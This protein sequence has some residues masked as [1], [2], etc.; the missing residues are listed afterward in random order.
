MTMPPTW[1]KNLSSP[2]IRRLILLST[3]V[4]VDPSKLLR[5]KQTL[6]P[7]IHLPSQ[8]QLKQRRL[9]RKPKRCFAYS[10]YR[11]LNCML[12]CLRPNLASSKNGQ[13]PLGMKGRVNWL[14]LLP[15]EI[16][17]NSNYMGSSWDLRLYCWQRRN[18]ETT[19]RAMRW[20][21][22]LLMLTDI[23]PLKCSWATRLRSQLN[24]NWI[25]S[26]FQRRPL[27]ASI[28]PL[29]GKTKT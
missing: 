18:R 16:R 4:W 13:R 29:L 25:T 26:S 27:S 14:R 20:T 8:R 7:N 15:M 24:G 11:L 6:V 17:K 1:F 5:V 23:E 28:R 22:A 12:N 19:M 9:S 3:L 2:I 21:S 10:L